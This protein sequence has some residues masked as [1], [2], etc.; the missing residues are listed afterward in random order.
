[1]LSIFLV[2]CFI[3]GS[4]LLEGLALST[5]WGWFVVPLG[6]ADIG[7]AHAL[8]LSLTLS[9]VTNQYSDWD[10]GDAMEDFGKRIKWSLTLLGMC[11]LTGAVANAYM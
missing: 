2:L 3:A 1:M 9:L 8:G 7:V 4:A 5:M 11:L 6:V 10:T